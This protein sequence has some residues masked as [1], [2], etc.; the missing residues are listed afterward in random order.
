MQGEAQGWQRRVEAL[1]SQKKV[2]DT[3]AS[4][5]KAPPCPPNPN[6]NPN[7]NPPA[8]PPCLRPDPR[9][10]HW[11]AEKEGWIANL[12]DS[13]RQLEATAFDGHQIDPNAPIPDPNPNINAN[14]NPDANPN[15]NPNPN[16][17]ATG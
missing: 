4:V 17:P 16:I 10:L 14:P 8:Q 3:Q 2:E 7:P 13:I 12:E 6:P 9:S 15:P 11:Q 1:R 5:L